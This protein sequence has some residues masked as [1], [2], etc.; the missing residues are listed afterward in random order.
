MH[1]TLPRVGL[2]TVGRVTT[3]GLLFSYRL[4]VSCFHL[5][6]W[7]AQL[8]YPHHVPRIR[9]KKEMAITPLPV[10]HFCVHSVHNAT[11]LQH[12]NTTFIPCSC[13]VADEHNTARNMFDRMFGNIL[14]IGI[15]TKCWGPK[16]WK[17]RQWYSRQALVLTKAV[18]THNRLML[19]VPNCS[20]ITI[21]LL[22]S[23]N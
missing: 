2:Q 7:W 11:L 23:N 6:H 1:L 16:I 4:R 18:H 3:K 10:L 9:M 17:Y 20:M 21:L 19:I 5:L 22:L 12:I 8:K 15:L 14:T 13:Q